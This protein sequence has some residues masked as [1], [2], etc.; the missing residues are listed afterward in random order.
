MVTEPLANSASSKSDQPPSMKRQIE[1]IESDFVLP[2]KPFKPRER[3]YVRPDIPTKNSF[4]SLDEENDLVSPEENYPSDTDKN[5]FVQTTSEDETTPNKTP[6]TLIDKEKWDQLS[7]IIINKKIN[8]PNA[9]N[10]A[11]SIKILPSTVED[12]RILRK[13][14]TDKD[15][16]YFTHDN[17]NE[18]TLKVVIRGIITESRKTWNPKDTQQKKSPE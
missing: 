6:I 15:F 12:Y 2:K 10:T 3:T 11:R 7:K 13:L 16:R 1:N 4:D 5:D 8:A 9:T 14:M 17:K 18:R